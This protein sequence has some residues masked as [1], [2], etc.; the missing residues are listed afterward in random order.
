MAEEYLTACGEHQMP[1]LHKGLECPWCRLLAD[2]QVA[3]EVEYKRGFKDGVQATEKES[4][5]AKRGDVGL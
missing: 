2:M 1:I 5:D 3:L 4:S